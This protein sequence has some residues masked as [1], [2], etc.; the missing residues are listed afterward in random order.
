MKFLD[1]IRAQFHSF[2]WKFQNWRDGPL[3]PKH[4][5]DLRKALQSGVREGFADAGFPL[6]IEP[7]NATLKSTTYTLDQ[8][9]KF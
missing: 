7:L 2:L 5:E 9:K 3:D 4:I 6:K 8:L 1:F